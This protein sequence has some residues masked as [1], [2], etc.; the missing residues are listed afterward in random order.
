MKI[1]EFSDSHLKGTKCSNTEALLDIAA[2]EKPDLLI[3]NGDV[4]DFWAEKEGVI[5]QNPT[6]KKLDLLSRDVPTMLLV[7]N[8][9]FDID[10]LK[11]LSPKA[12]IAFNYYADGLW[13]EHGHLRDIFWQGWPILRSIFDARP[14]WAH[15]VFWHLYQPWRERFNLNPGN[16]KLKI[17]SIDFA[18][19][20]H[21]RTIWYRT[22][23]FADWKK[24]ER[25]IIIGHDHTFGSWVPEYKPQLWNGGSIRDDGTYLA[26]SDGVP[27]LKRV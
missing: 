22:L 10:A 6:V 23:S 20:Q 25:G 5:A 16:R 24:I 21:S 2:K 3:G 18:Y 7:G 17:G 12:E 1:L 27:E 4:I 9:D 8:H 11:R 14:E 19:R 13:F 15:W 26:I